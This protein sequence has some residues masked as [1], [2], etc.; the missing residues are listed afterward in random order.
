MH[1]GSILLAHGLSPSWGEPGPVASKD[2]G[3]PKATLQ[4]KPK[5]GPQK[6]PVPLNHPWSPP[7]ALRTYGADRSLGDPWVNA[8]PWWT[9]YHIAESLKGPGEPPR[10]SNTLWG[11]CPGRI[12]KERPSC[13][14]SM[15]WMGQDAQHTLISQLTTLCP[16]SL[17]SKP[18]LGERSRQMLFLQA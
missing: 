5:T 4:R 15:G 12:P 3:V 6:A 13:L 1:P 14:H 8:G 17:P 7:W 18:W 2:Q 11:S 10:S 9:L 16:V